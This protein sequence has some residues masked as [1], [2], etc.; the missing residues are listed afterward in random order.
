MCIRACKH[1]VTTPS[2]LGWPR[3]AL[4]ATPLA[5]KSRLE[6]KYTIS[7]PSWTQGK[8]QGSLF[9]FWRVESKLNFEVICSGT[10]L[11]VGRTVM[12]S[13]IDLRP[14]WRGVVNK[15]VIFAIES[16][17]LAGG[18]NTYKRTFDV[19]QLPVTNN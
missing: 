18:T 10:C 3:Y 11:W 19:R 7:P 16:S 17:H 12:S 2:M 9:S 8:Q 13:H 6:A 4:L 5:I 14:P 15:K 1:R